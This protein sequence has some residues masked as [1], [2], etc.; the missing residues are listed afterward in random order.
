MI[1]NQT[2]KLRKCHI[3][4]FIKK[5]YMNLVKYKACSFIFQIRSVVL[6]LWL[7]IQKVDAKYLLAA[8]K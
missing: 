4:N 1:L 6:N 5:K 8:E 3:I 2:E 7:V